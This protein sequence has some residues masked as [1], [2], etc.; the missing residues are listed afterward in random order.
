MHFIANGQ[1]NIPQLINFQA[2]ARD[3]GGAI[4][5]NQNI[6]VRFTVRQGG[7]NG[8]AIYCAAHNQTTNQFGSFSV[9]LNKN[10]TAFNCNGANTTF[11]QID[12]SA[13]QMFIQV[14]YQPQGASVFTDL[15]AFEVAATPYSFASQL[16]EKVKDIKTSGANNGEVLKYNQALQ[17]FEP[18]VDNTGGSN[19]VGGTGITINGNTI[20][21]NWSLSPNGSDIFNNNPGG[22]GIGR[23]TAG[24]PVDIF[25]NTTT[26]EGQVR[27]QTDSAVVAALRLQT[28]L[29]NFS[30]NS[31]NTVKRFSIVDIDSS[32]IRFAINEN[33]F[34]GI[35]TAFPQFKLDVWGASQPEARFFADSGKAADIQLQTDSSMWNIFANGQKNEFC[36][37]DKKI[38]TTRLLIDE[39]GDVNIGYAGQKPQ[40]KLDVNG[41][42]RVTDFTMTGNAPDVGKVLTSDA[43]GNAS[44]QFISGKVVN[45]FFSSYYGN[46]PTT[47][48]DFIGP[49]VDVTIG[50]GQTIMVNVCKA[51]GSS[52]GAVD[53][54]LDIAYLDLAGGTITGVGNNMYGLS[55]NAGTRIP[56]PMNGVISGLPAGTYRVGMA[57]SSSDAT[58]WDSNEYG[59]ITVTIIE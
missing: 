36:I 38:T 2:V 25:S 31:S 18:G 22:I 30:I 16:A 58:N 47:T 44:W 54:G 11:E 53:L 50:N 15:G 46:D 6:Y 34:V 17:Q 28:P 59:Y 56:F 23:N 19:Y 14:E 5:V 9:Q 37:F 13:G 12:W 8:T 4:A 45:T 32:I 55:V 29:S 52:V 7:P 26:P 43:N 20:N 48:Y 1:T 40:A 3:A 21:S 35:G 27:I 49:T 42:T 57:G 41:R 33:G 51:L 10:V 24:F 39:N